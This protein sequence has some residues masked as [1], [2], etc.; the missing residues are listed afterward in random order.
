[1]PAAKEIDLNFP[2]GGV[3]RS[4]GFSRQ[5]NIPLG[6]GRYGRTTPTAQNVMAR[7]I[8]TGRIRGATR[9]MLARYINAQPGGSSGLIQFIGLV[10]GVG[11]SAPGGSGQSNAAGLLKTIVVVKAG[12]PYVADVG[13]TSWTTPT[14]DTGSNPP[15]NSTGII[16][17]T[18]HNQKLYFFDGTH[19]CYYDPSLNQVKTWGASA[20]TFPANSS[21][22]YATFGGTYRGRVVHCI[23]QNW[24]MSEVDD[25][26]DY[27][28][29]P[30]STSPTQAVAGNN[31]SLGLVGDILTGFVPFGDDYAIFGSDHAL[32]LLAGDPMAGGQIG[33]VSDKVGMAFGQAWCKGPDNA[34]YFFSNTRR[35]FRMGRGEAPQPISDPIDSML[36]S[37]NTGTYTVTMEWN[38]L[39]RAF[40]VFITKTASAGSAQHFLWDQS[41]GGWFPFNFGNINHNPLCCATIDGNDADDRVMLIGSWDGY[42]RCFSL[43]A[44]KDD[45]TDCTSEV[46][47]GPI[48]TDTFEAMELRELQP[49]FGEDS[50]NVTY[51]IYVGR[52]AEQALESTA[53]QTGTFRAGR[54]HTV[55][56]KRAGHAIYVK[57]TATSPWA[58]EK[59]RTSVV[60]KQYAKRR[61]VY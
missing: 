30:A 40:V 13:G 51:S 49:E 31:S 2:V 43:S 37:I 47:L 52:T 55:H 27:N 60:G 29:S 45:G 50:G 54:G 26:T 18:V 41:T 48:V 33:L 35:I 57:L 17:G 21:G 9:P 58:I 7:E 19:T 46:W 56:V 14:N 61:K 23:A 16:R 22:A 15:L 1:M 25:A 4:W 38:D 53:V 32:H 11:Y 6:D 24:L 44:V 8:S 28:Y 12:I 36:E 5:P 39:M 20:G 42:V 10:T 3:N 34:L 59:I